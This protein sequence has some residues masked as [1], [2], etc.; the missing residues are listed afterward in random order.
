MRDRI[1]SYHQFTLDY[2]LVY[3]GVERSGAERSTFTVFTDSMDF[4][5]LFVLIGFALVTLLLLLLLLLLLTNMIRVAL[6]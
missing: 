6:S 1:A 3:G 2:S 5:R 4:F